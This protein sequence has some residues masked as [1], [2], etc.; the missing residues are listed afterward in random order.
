MD[1]GSK[2]PRCDYAAF[3]KFSCEAEPNHKAAI[4]GC[5]CASIDTNDAES[6]DEVKAKNFNWTV[7]LYDLDLAASPIFYISL[8]KDGQNVTDDD[9]TFSAY[10]N[11]TEADAS[12]TTATGTV[13]AA[14]ASGSHPAQTAVITPTTTAATDSSGTTSS[15]GGS[16][17]NSNQGQSSGGLSTGAQAGIGVGVGISALAAIVCAAALFFYMRRNGR[18]NIESAQQ[19]QAMTP[20]PTE[21]PVYH[22][23]YHS[24]YPSIYPS[25]YP[26]PYQASE[27][28]HDDQQ[29][30]AYRQQQQKQDQPEMRVISELYAP[31]PSESASPN[32]PQNHTATYR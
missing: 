15:G 13:A 10:F 5:P 20:K 17:G 2:N 9:Y 7:Q 18:R 24:G 32:S 6:S 14:T 4:E 25:G 3:L 28:L 21:P 27:M 22:S 16:I 19:Q 1:A 29:Q 8:Y 11:I 12:I 23:G 31:L 30:T 26:S